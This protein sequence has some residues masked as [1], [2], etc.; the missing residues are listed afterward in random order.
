MASTHWISNLSKGLF[1]P[2][3]INR[4]RNWLQDGWVN[5]WIFESFS[6]HWC[7]TLF[8]RHHSNCRHRF[9]HMSMWNRSDHIGVRNRSH[10]MNRS[11]RIG[12]QNRSHLLEAGITLIVSCVLVGKSICF[13]LQK[14]EGKGKTNGKG[15]D[16]KHTFQSFALFSLNPTLC[17]FLAKKIRATRNHW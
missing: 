5:F 7:Q 2:R 3:L 11:H 14:H 1:T 6:S 16:L 17:N 9:H 8:I 15:S 10:D 4:F 12:G 13:F